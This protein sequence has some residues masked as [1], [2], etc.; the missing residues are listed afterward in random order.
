MKDAKGYLSKINSL[1]AK[2]TKDAKVSFQTPGSETFSEGNTGMG[3]GNWLTMRLMPLRMWTISMH[4]QRPAASEVD[5]PR[6]DS[7]FCKAFLRVL[8]VLGREAFDLDFREMKAFSILIFEEL[9]SR[10]LCPWR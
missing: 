2:D 3:A 10:P 5:V 9:P 1:T 4:P 6:Q 8:R 7:R